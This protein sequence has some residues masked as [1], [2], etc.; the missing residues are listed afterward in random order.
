MGIRRE[1]PEVM[2][3]S[4]EWEEMHV[5]IEGKILK[6]TDQFKFLE[7]SYKSKNDMSMELNIK[8]KRILSFK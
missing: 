4:K 3:M 7:M 6:Q 8:I 1:K 5:I 2:L